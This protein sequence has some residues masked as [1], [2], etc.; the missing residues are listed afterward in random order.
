MKTIKYPI[1]HDEEGGSL[2][3][4]GKL[5][6]PRLVLMCAGYP[7]DQSVFMPLAERL[8][9]KNCLVGVTCL[10]GYDKIGYKDGYT[11]Q[12]CGKCMAEAA[13]ALRAQSTAASRP[14]LSGIFH[15][16][17][18][19][20]GTIFT[21]QALENESD[22]VPDEVVL[23]DVCLPV[24]PKTTDTKHLEIKEPTTS[25]AIYSFAVFFAYQIL[26]ATCFLLQRYVSKRL[27]A[28]YHAV[29]WK[30]ISWLKLVPISSPQDK[31]Y[32]KTRQVSHITYLMYAYYYFWKGILY[33]PS[34]LEGCCLPLDLKKTPVLFLYGADKAIPFHDATNVAV[35]RE[36][37]EQG[38]RSNAVEIKSAGHWLYLHQQD[39]CFDKV[40]K[41]LEL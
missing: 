33:N 38:R 6:A 29:G 40:S 7:D 23:F 30:F 32:I 2:F 8:A 20:A 19:V 12:E 18:C 28:L 27:A 10:P 31:A 39:E 11:F 37:Q 3:L 4:V 22:V 24:H 14:K 25:T 16:W 34:D 9:Q 35:L 15:D 13:K 21:N 36:E 26:F 41:F 1:L 5:D 17:G